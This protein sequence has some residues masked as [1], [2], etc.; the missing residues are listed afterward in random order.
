VVV[1]RL[2]AEAEKPDLLAPD[3]CTYPKKLEVI[4]AI[5]SELKER[6]S[7]QGARDPFLRRCSVVEGAARHLHKLVENPG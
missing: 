3:Y 2:T 7:W 6:G 1:H 5:L 4:E